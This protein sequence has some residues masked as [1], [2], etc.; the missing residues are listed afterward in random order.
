MVCCLLSGIPTC[1][2]SEKETNKMKGMEKKGEQI[3]KLVLVSNIKY[4]NIHSTMKISTN[5]V[6]LSVAWLARIL[7]SS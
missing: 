1:L 3:N 4:A 7:K 2:L 6:C 5:F